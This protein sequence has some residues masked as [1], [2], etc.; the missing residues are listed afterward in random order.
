MVSLSMVFHG[1]P[2]LEDEETF[3]RIRDDGQT[4]RQDCYKVFGYA[5]S[6]VYV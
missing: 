1:P 3:I 2:K 4:K 6:L 5:N